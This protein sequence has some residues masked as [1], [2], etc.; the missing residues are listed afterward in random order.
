MGKQV[1]LPALGVPVYTDH[2]Y[3]WFEEGGAKGQG[4]LSSQELHEKA[5]R[6][7][8][9]YFQDGDWDEI[10][11][12]VGSIPKWM[13][14]LSAALIQYRKRGHIAKRGKYYYFLDL[15]TLYPADRSKP[16]KVQKI[17]PTKKLFLYT[18]RVKRT[19]RRKKG[20]K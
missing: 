2:L 19:T 9:P 3:T 10:V 1:R 18:D 6:D 15:C 12:A 7:L 14:Q 8:S 4:C 5:Y 20:G 17:E 11:N 13:N 16:K